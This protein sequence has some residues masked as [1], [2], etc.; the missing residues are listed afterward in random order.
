S[1][2]GKHTVTALRARPL[3]GG[4]DTW[5]VKPPGDPYFGDM[6]QNEIHFM[7]GVGTRV[8]FQRLDSGYQ[9]GAHANH[10]D[11]RTVQAVVK[12][13]DPPDLKSMLK[14]PHPDYAEGV[15]TLA[16]DAAAEDDC[17]MGEK[18]A[19]SKAYLNGLGLSAT[20]A[21]VDAYVDVIVAV[22]PDVEW[23]QNCYFEESLDL[24]LKHLKVAAA[25]ERLLTAAVKMLQVTGVLGYSRMKVGGAQRAAVLKQFAAAGPAPLKPAVAANPA[26]SSSKIKEGRKLT[27]G[28][29]YPEAIKAFD[30]AIAADAS[31]AKAWSGRGF[32]RMQ[33]GQLAKAKS[34]LEHAR[35]LRKAAARKIKA[36]R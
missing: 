20:K 16:T 3:A 36:L 6:D 21:G 22:D 32:A 35:T 27:R 12:S 10:D 2:T 4:A 31:A 26:R 11:Y 17:E 13:Q 30:A 18:Y 29:Q 34:D 1:A 24:P 14:L 33:A 28:K 25:D 7:G 15:K 8:F 9:C 19:A 5:L 23:A